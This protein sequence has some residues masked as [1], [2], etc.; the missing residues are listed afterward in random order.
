MYTVFKEIDKS[1]DNRISFDE[2]RTAI[3]FLNKIGIDVNDDYLIRDTFNEIDSNNGGMIL[4][5]ELITWVNNKWS[6]TEFYED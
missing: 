3:P 2:F 4:F 5:D 6:K 1:N